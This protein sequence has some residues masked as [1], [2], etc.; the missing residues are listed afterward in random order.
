MSINDIAQDNV[1]PPSVGNEFDE[2]KFS[3]IEVDDLF[4]PHAVN[5]DDNPAYRKISETEGGNTKTR[6]SYTFNQNQVVYVRT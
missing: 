5:A 2:T 6:I 3:E 1:N 4:W